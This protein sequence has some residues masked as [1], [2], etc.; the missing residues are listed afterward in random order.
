MVAAAHS[1]SPNRRRSSLLGYRDDVVSVVLAVAIAVVVV[2]IAFVIRSR[3]PTDVPTQRTYGSPSQLDRADFDATQ[4]WLVVVFTSASCHVCSDVAAKA[5]VLESR[6]VGVCELEF[7]RDRRLHERY[8]IEAV[9]TTLV[10]DAQGVV[11]RALLGPVSATDLWIAVADA[12][13]PDSSRE[14]RQ[15]AS[16]D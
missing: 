4:D 14:L 16:H 9:P 15:C 1:Q 13:E 10:C 6:S 7:T 8:A 12:R 3:R 2:A 5:R 11:H